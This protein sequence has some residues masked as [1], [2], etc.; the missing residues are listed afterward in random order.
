MI[1]TD[2]L[3][4]H[5]DEPAR[6]ERVAGHSM[7][8]YLPTQL[9]GR[10]VDRAMLRAETKQYPDGEWFAEIPGFPGVWGSQPSEEA[11]V[12][13]LRETL[14]EW[15]LLKIR[16]KDRDLPVVDSINLNVL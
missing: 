14:H 10:Y 1:R 11:A 4:A 13:E 3:H 6:V 16:D 9:I 5:H 7:Q 12:V 8:R 15:V 2:E